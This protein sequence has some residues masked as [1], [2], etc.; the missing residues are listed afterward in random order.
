METMTNIQ[1]KA[2][3]ALTWFESA[4]R[5]ENDPE[6]AFTRT[7]D[8]APE[9]VTDLVRDA[10]GEF[11]PD[12]WRYD[13]IRDALE[14]IAESDDPEDSAEFADQAVDVYTSDRLAWLS[15]NL[16]RAS[17][18]DDARENLGATNSIIDDIGLG[19]YQEAGEIYGS[20]LNSLESL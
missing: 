10:H 15:S 19:Q 3:E 18:V 4:R 2:T 1:D 8:G 14:F 7:K 6:S 11:L 20:V 13:K 5:D 16:R 9:W 17:Y 12:D